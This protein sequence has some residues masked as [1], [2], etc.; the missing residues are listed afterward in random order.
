ML[1]KAQV[2]SDLSAWDTVGGRDRVWGGR[3][4]VLL[5]SLVVYAAGL[6]HGLSRPWTGMHDWNGAFFSQLARNFLRYPAEVHHGMPLVA[7]GEAV[8]APDE[9]SIYATHPPMLVWLVAGAF[10][11]LGEAEWVA[12]LVPVMFSLGAMSLLVWL[13]ARGWGVETALL[14]GLTYGV[15]PMAAY[16]GRMVD[17][18]AVCLCLM[19][20]AVAAWT[21]VVDENA[22]SRGKRRL[23]WALWAIAM[24][25]VIWVDWSG[26]VFAGVFAVYAGIERAR[27]RIDR[28][29]L[30][31]AWGLPAVACAGMLVYLVYAGLDGRWGDLIAIFQSRATGAEGGALLKDGSAR[32]GVWDYTVEN[33]TWPVITLSAVCVVLSAARLYKGL[34][35]GGGEQV[36][37][38]TARSPVR[39]F[40]VVTA[41]GVVWLLVFWRQYERHNYWLFY[42]GPAAAVSSAR[43]LIAV[44]D[45]VRGFGWRRTNELIFAAMAVVVAF[46]LAGTDDYFGRVSYPPEEVAAWKGIRARTGAYD[47]LLLFRNPVRSERR[48]GYV[49]RNLVP[50]QEAYYLDRAFDV[51]SDLE[52]VASRMSEYA[53]FVIPIQDALVRGEDL[54][55]LRRRFAEEQVLVKLLFRPSGGGGVSADA[56]NSP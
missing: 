29:A 12:R 41:T 39:G 51:E 27:G 14:A 13:V 55:M 21:K 47:R 46:G 30:I 36:G 7:V 19:L 9:R 49:F 10:C 32:G 15:M 40:W 48:G 28:A 56:I 3:Y 25:S 22:G 18:E 34:A 11:V 37:G 43:A 26:M 44:R 8:P 53:G 23:I 16:F 35:G 45:W 38:D 1:T 20:A 2:V 17:H 33:L 6:T 5:V 42:L 31:L 24:W 54:G 50:P 52:V 4:G